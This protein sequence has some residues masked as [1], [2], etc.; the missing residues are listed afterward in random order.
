ML[1]DD[2]SKPRWKI[3][4][5]AQRSWLRGVLGRGAGVPGLKE[6]L[7]LDGSADALAA[8]DRFG[9]TP[10]HIAA[11]YGWDQAIT[12]LVE[13]GAGRGAADAAGETA[14]HLAVKARVDLPALELLCNGASVPAKP[15]DTTVDRHHAILNTPD[16]DG[17]TPL[18]VA[19]LVRNAPAAFVLTR[20]GADPFL[21]NREGM[22][23]SSVACARECGEVSFLVD[24]AVAWH[25]AGVALVAAAAAACQQAVYLRRRRVSF[26]LSASALTAKARQ[27]VRLE[28]ELRTSFSSIPS[29]DGTFQDVASRHS[30]AS[31]T[32]TSL[33]MVPAIVEDLLSD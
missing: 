29:V 23:P 6:L 28:S 14:L 16:R 9:R 26:N 20:C 31:S 33:R 15:M 1:S 19:A 27:M 8:A 21:V 22:T 25:C 17:N 13:A 32:S 10:L 30:N 24:R 2:A 3:T 7:A 18:H 12:V 4:D 5:T 11:E